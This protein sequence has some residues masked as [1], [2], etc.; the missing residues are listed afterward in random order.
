MLQEQLVVAG[1]VMSHEAAF[2]AMRMHCCLMEALYTDHSNHARDM[3]EPQAALNYYLANA[4][5]TCLEA[6]K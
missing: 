6:S 1:V 2:P 4:N 3:F 5:S